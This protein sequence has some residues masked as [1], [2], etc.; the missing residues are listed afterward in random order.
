MAV[1]SRRSFIRN[2]AAIS[3]LAVF[4]RLSLPW[5]KESIIMT[6]NGPVNAS[7]LGT[8]LIHEHVLVDFIGA[9][10]VSTTRYDA[11]EVFETALPFLKELKDRG[12]KAIFECTPAFLGRDVKLLQRLSKASGIHII[13]NSGFYGASNQK[14]MPSFVTME[15]ADQIAERWI[16]EWENGIDGTGIKPGFLKLG[17]DNV[18]FTDEI[19]KIITA[20]AI[21]HLRTGLTIGVHTS[22]G[23]KPATEELRII[24][25][26]KVLPNAWIWIHA[27]NE[28]D[29]SYHF[30]LA[31]KGAWIS[32]DGLS[33]DSVD[34]YLEILRKMKE[35]KLLKKVLLSHDAGWYHVDEPKGGNFRGYTDLFEYFLPALKKSGFTNEDINLI[36][37]RNPAEAFAIK[38]RR[39]S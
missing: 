22:N 21:T 19:K 11:N 20:G 39:A 15:T 27:Q 37:V 5:A 16:K 9:D 38:V 10:K 25:E 32:F 1:F 35:K 34:D 8:S 18:P 23:G 14:F 3:G 26:N 29:L 33:K 28:K 2:T 30:D 12:C 24:T 31:A 4:S 17:V 7:L 13:S 36:L 6:V